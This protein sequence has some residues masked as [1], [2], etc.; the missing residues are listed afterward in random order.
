MGRYTLIGAVLLVVASWSQPASAQYGFGGGADPSAQ[1]EA[2]RNKAKRGRSDYTRKGGSGAAR[3]SSIGGG[4]RDD[5]GRIDLS[6]HRV[7]GYPAIR[8]DLSHARITRG[9]ANG[10]A[11]RGV[12]RRPGR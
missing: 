4:F 5:S 3:R 11:R 7:P 2:A 1:I 6:G 9:G 8:G 12:R 10:V